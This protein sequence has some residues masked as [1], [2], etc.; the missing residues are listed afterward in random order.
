MP[1]D[2]TKQL[3]H[4]ECLAA[5]KMAQQFTGNR[6]IKVF[7]DVAGKTPQEIEEINQYIH[8]AYPALVKKELNAFDLAALKLDKNSVAD[9]YYEM[10]C[11]REAFQPLEKAYQAM[12]AD[13]GDK[14]I[15]IEAFQRLFATPPISSSPMTKVPNV[16]HVIWLG[17]YP[18]QNTLDNVAALAR[19]NPQYTVKLWVDPRF[20]TKQENQRLKLWAQPRNVEI[21]DAK[22][23]YADKEFQQL[24]PAANMLRNYEAS[25]F[26]GE[27]I[28]P[29]SM[30]YHVPLSDQLRLFILKKEGGHYLDDDLV[31]KKPLPL[32][33][34]LPEGFG[35]Y[36]P[37]N[38]SSTYIASNCII[39]AAKDSDV[40]NTYIQLVSQGWT[41]LMKMPVKGVDVDVGQFRDFVGTISGPFML[42]L[43]TGE[44]LEPSFVSMLDAFNKNERYQSMD[45]PPFKLLCVDISMTRNW[46]AQS[47]YRTET[48]R[49]PLSECVEVKNESRYGANQASGPSARASKSFK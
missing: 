26:K 20:L 14:P 22:T 41:S 28:S 32:D 30:N 47:M 11:R 25:R 17:G 34:V 3:I 12:A 40:L 10:P 27:E 6:V 18:K 15:S 21:A 16:A 1:N 13:A 48:Y 38:P 46:G 29:I 4:D 39:S 24:F 9:I 36:S 8:Q 5:F 44:R 35:I 31:P 2:V 19:D 49:S 45:I 23:L 7:I 42:G 37:M 33:V 43:V